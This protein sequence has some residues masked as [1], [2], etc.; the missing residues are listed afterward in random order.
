M[1]AH[2]LLTPCVASACAAERSTGDRKCIYCATG[3][4]AMTS[5]GAVGQTGSTK[6]SQW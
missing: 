3:S 2:W 6:C 5:A 1:V 4:V